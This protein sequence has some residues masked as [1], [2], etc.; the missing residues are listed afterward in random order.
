M[1][2]VAQ[3]GSDVSEITGT[4]RWTAPIVGADRKRSLWL[5]CLIAL[6]ALLVLGNLVSDLTL[7]VK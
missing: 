7:D 6:V 1:E 4:A 3:T 5:D 2:L